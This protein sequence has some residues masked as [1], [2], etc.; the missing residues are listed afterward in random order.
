MSD[1]H[2]CLV[3]MRIKINSKLHLPGYAFLHQCI[4]FRTIISEIYKSIS[5]CA[6]HLKS[7]ENT[8]PKSIFDPLLLSS[9]TK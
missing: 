8:V 3:R 2:V 6:I 1:I 4:A 7:D 5:L 9:I